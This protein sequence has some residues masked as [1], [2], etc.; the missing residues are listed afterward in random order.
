MYSCKLA[1]L[2]EIE[3]FGEAKTAKYGT[4]FLEVLQEAL[5]EKRNEAIREPD[6]TDSGS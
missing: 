2:Q 1:G 4:A 5:G 3:G 6:G